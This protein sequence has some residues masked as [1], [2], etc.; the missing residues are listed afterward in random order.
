MS[1]VKGEVCRTLKA[2]KKNFLE[3]TMTI[4]SLEAKCEML[5]SLLVFMNYP[6]LNTVNCAPIK[7]AFVFSPLQEAILLG[8]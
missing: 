5:P 6:I 7:Q 2:L 3:N 4:Y 8:S 1:A